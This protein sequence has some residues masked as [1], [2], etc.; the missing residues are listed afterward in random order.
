MQ[1]NHYLLQ[2]DIDGKLINTFK[3]KKNVLDKFFQLYNKKL[4]YYNLY[5]CC[6]LNGSTNIK[7]KYHGYYWVWGKFFIIPPSTIKIKKKKYTIIQYDMFNGNFIKEYRTYDEAANELKVQ[8]QYIIKCC[9]GIHKTVDKK[10]ICT[11]R[12][13]DEKLIEQLNIKEYFKY[14]PQKNIKL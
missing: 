14:V 12:F 4:N 2:Y 3:N 10:Y 7:H 6:T 13:E 8:K 9:N 5:R 11:K 1:F